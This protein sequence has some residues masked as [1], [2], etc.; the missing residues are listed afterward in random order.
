MTRTRTIN[1]VHC[2][3]VGFHFYMICF[4]NIVVFTR[5]T[6]KRYVLNVNRENKH[7]Y[8]LIAK[9]IHFT[10]YRFIKYKNQKKADK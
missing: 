7:A 4:Y 2:M 3:Q 5:L 10:V 1:T 8:V 9:S 6:I